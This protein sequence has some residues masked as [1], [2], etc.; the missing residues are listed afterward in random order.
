MLF[1]SILLAT[2]FVHHS[3]KLV[4]GFAIK[5]SPS[6]RSLN[7]N[8]EVRYDRPSSYFIRVENVPDIHHRPPLIG[9][10]GGMGPASTR[11]HELVLKRDQNRISQEETHNCCVCDSA[12]SGFLSDSQYTRFLLN[13]NPQVP[14]NSM[15]ALG[16]GPSSERELSRTATA[17]RHAGA[18]IVAFA[19]TTADSWQDQVSQHAHIP[20]LDLLGCIAQR[21][22]N[23]GHKKVG[24]LY[25]DGTHVR[26]EFSEGN[27]TTWIG[28]RHTE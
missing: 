14:N 24:L 17:L 25:V 15:A 13:N 18:D 21:V 5:T 4:D 6:T 26:G 7:R 8:D 2:L 20:I 27:R 19:C 22:Q 12:A 16:L 23:E 1:A 9:I 11:L 3:T 10:I 28:C